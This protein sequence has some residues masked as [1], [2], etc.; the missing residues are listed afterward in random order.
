VVPLAYVLVRGV[1]EFDWDF[2][3][4]KLGVLVVWFVIFSCAWAAAAPAADR[5]RSRWVLNAAPAGAV[6][7]LAIIAAPL[8][9]QA[10]ALSLPGMD[11]ELVL[12]R[13]EASDASFHLIRDVL[14]SQSGEAAAFYSF[15][16]ANSGLRSLIEPTDVDFDTRLAPPSGQQPDVYIIIVDSLRRDYLSPYNP[17]VAFTPGIAA[18]AAE[19]FVFERAFTRYGG[20]ALSVPSIYTGGMVPHKQYVTPY[21]R[22]NTLEKLLRAK[23]YRQYISPDH[24]VSRLFAKVP[25]TVY[26]EGRDPLARDAGHT[27][28]GHRSPELSYTVCG[29][30][31]EL[32]AAMAQ[33]ERDRPIFAMTRTLDLHLSNVM[34]QDDPDLERLGDF[35]APYAARV[36]RLDGCLGQFIT[37]LK[38]TNQYDNSVIVLTADH[39]ESIGD[40][41]RWGHSYTLYP[42]VVQIPL[43]V[44]LP[45]RYRGAF[46]TDLGR[47]AFSTDIT[48]SLYALLGEEP[49]DLGP[50]YGSPLFVE[51]GGLPR[52]RADGTY[53]LSSSYG[54][55]FALLS[56][57]GRHLYIADAIDGRDYAYDL[58]DPNA[59]T[60]MTITTALRAFS[61]KR[62]HEQVSAI[63]VHYRI[64]AAP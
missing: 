40:E 31:G 7:V 15:L 19:S 41:N 28:R 43:I 18:F 24:I 4:Q 16:K 35:S 17:Q 53:V 20:T 55:V 36:E 30:L 10:G 26:L 11:M 27:A 48:P 62:I 45:E 60:R 57:G 23:G 8:Q 21:A 1:A 9:R 49:A 29:K 5:R 32:Q 63:A 52:N 51:R 54:P 61:W 14:R 12:D 64:P 6:L 44:H 50:L 58:T 56:H 59:P 3:F 2:L 13:Y 22:L 39:G 42:E 47:L 33:R 25:D 37:Y 34:G 38:Q 46:T